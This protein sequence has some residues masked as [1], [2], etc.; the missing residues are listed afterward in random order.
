MERLIPM[1]MKV[2]VCVFRGTV[3]EIKKQWGE[4]CW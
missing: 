4:Y 3:T 1:N 2:V